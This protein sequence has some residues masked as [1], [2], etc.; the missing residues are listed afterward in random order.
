MGKRIIIE[1]V[2][3]AVRLVIITMVVTINYSK[4]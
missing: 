1:T 2:A 3:E 4:K